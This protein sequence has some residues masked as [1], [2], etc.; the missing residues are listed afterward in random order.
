VRYKTQFIESL[1]EQHLESTTNPTPESTTNSL[2]RWG[3]SANLTGNDGSWLGRQ[4][5]RRNR[6]REIVDGHVD[7]H[8]NITYMNEQGEK[9]GT[10]M[11]MNV[12]AHWEKDIIWE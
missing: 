2:L 4:I 3:E 11:K 8:E 9:V 5:G 1:E 10:S 6:Q 7:D 12:L